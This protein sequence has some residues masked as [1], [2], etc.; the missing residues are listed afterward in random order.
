MPEVPSMLVNAHAARAPS[1]AAYK[2]LYTATQD[3]LVSIHVNNGNATD[4]G[5][6]IAIVDEAAAYVD[7]ATPPAYSFVTGKD[8]QSRFL[9]AN[10]EIDTPVYNLSD[11]DMVVVWTD[12][13]GVTFLNQGFLFS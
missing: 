7:G 10:Q 4:S 1:A 3:A 6:R 5:Y 13:T 9:E 8:G 11:G 2:L 12:N